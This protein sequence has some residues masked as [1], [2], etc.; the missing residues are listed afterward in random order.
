MSSPAKK[1]PYTPTGAPTG[2]VATVPVEHKRIA[3]LAF[4][5]WEARGHPDGS[6]EQDWFRAE[7]ELR[8]RKSAW[9]IMKGQH[10]RAPRARIIS[11][12]GD[13]GAL[14]QTTSL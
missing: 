14:E 11:R 1:K 6:P 13:G 8:R 4:F 2:E 7:E 5:Y 3:R 10:L 12:S 9:A